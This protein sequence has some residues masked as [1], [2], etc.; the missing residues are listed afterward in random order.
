M[1]STLLAIAQTR[2]ELLGNEFEIEKLRVLRMLLLAQVLMFA[3]LIVALLA[4]S[5]LTLWLWEFRLGVLAL[6]IALFGAAA[7]WAYRSLMAMVQRPESTFASSL[8]ELQEDLRRLK[9]ASGHATTPD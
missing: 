4:T 7:W 1:A 8:T 9:A 6:C 3:M 2:L 5:L